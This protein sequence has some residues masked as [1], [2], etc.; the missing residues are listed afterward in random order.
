[1]EEPIVEPIVETVQ[2]PKRVLTE[3]QLLALKK[4]REA[5]A[6]KRRVQKVQGEDK[7]EDKGEEYHGPYSG[8]CSI[9]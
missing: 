5:L 4:G 1:M 6:E 9:I 8:L 7:S 2:K 3:A